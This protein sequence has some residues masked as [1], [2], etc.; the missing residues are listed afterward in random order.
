LVGR[1]NGAGRALMGHRAAAKNF[2]IW[3]WVPD[4]LLLKERQ[5]G[6]RVE[7]PNA[8]RESTRVRVARQMECCNLPHRNDLPQTQI[9]RAHVASPTTP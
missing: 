6:Y 3:V 4:G 9:A 5:W 7:E 8:P 2:E 1:Y